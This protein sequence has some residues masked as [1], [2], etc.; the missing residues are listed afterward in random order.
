MYTLCFI[1]CL[2]HACRVYV[3]PQFDGFRDISRS[4]YFT[5]ALSYLAKTHGFFQFFLDIAKV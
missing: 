1:H 2:M 3:I 5:L 4:L